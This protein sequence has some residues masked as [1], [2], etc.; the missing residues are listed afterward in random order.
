MAKPF[1]KNAIVAVNGSKSSLQAAMHAIILAKQYQLSLKAVFVVD[2]ATIKY[3]TNFKLLTTSERDEYKQ[4]LV[5]D[6]KNYLE[7]VK[8]L[9]RTKGVKIETELREGPVAT[10]IIGAADQW[11]SDIIIVGRGDEYSMTPQGQVHKSVASANRRQIIINSHCSVFVAYKEDIEK[12]FKM[13]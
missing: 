6:G 10:E 11:H 4:N 5:N 1:I 8:D 7:Y 12:I 3:L 13:I 2:T 9:A